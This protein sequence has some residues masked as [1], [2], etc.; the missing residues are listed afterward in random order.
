MD[1][2]WDPRKAESNLAKHG[3]EF[4][5]AATVFGDPLAITYHDAEHS[6]HE[7]RF[8]TFGTTALG[9]LVAVVHVDRAYAAKTWTG[10]WKARISRDW[11]RKYGMPSRPTKPSTRH[12]GR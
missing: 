1:F 8:I 10:I 4:T 9:R 6:D 11:T 12:C 7:E 2:E 5:E 3:V